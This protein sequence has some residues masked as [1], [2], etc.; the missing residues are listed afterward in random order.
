ME[1]DRVPT[2]R[3][4][5]T[6]IG[7]PVGAHPLRRQPPRGVKKVWQG[8]G[9]LNRARAAPVPGTG[10]HGGWKPPGCANDNRPVAQV[11]RTA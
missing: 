1:G 5:V 4:P 11:A 8:P 6:G 9:R 3:D 10:R 2:V 7:R